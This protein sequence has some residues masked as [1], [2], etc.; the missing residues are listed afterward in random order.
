[1]YTIK[2]I[3]SKIIHINGTILMPDHTMPAHE[4]TAKLPSIQAF[5]K[6]KMLEI[7]A[8]VAEPPKQEEIAEEHDEQVG[9]GEESGENQSTDEQPKAKG[10]RRTAAKA[11]E[12]AQ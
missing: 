9:G 4:K 8:P 1:M 7:T 11:K 12:N 5:V 10:T 2:N 6:R 3:S